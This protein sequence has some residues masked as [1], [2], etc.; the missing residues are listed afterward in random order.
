MSSYVAIPSDQRKRH[1]KK[2][3]LKP[4]MLLIT[5]L[6]GHSGET[7]LESSGSRRF[8]ASLSNMTYLQPSQ[9]ASC[10][11]QSMAEA[12]AIIGELF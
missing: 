3:D 11:I 12:S 5:L 8:L 4:K 7:S 1:P 10:T 6:I 9:R 2:R